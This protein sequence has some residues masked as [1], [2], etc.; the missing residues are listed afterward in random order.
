M[1]ISEEMEEILQLEWYTERNGNSFEEGKAKPDQRVWWRCKEGHSW[2]AKM[3]SRIVRKSKCPYCS[4]VKAIIGENDVA[5]LYPELA[6]EF[7][8]TKNGDV[9]L[10]NYKEN[11]GKKVWWKCKKGHEWLA[12]INTRTKRGCGCP[13][14][15]GQKI[16]TGFNDFATLYPK[17]AKEV[18]PTK[19]TSVKIDSLGGK[20]H[21]KLI[22]ICPEGHEYSTTINKRVCRGDGCP[23]CAGRYPI[24]GVNDLKTLHPEAAKFWDNEINGDMQKYKSH[25][26][27][28]VSWKCSEG[29]KWINSIANQVNY[30]ECPYCD[31]RRLIIGVNDIETRYPAIALEWD[32]EKNG[33]EASKVKA[34]SKVQAYWKCAKGHSWK[35]YLSNRL[36]GKDCPYC[37]GKLPIKGENDLAT[38]YPWLVNEWNNELNRKRPEEYLPKSNRRVWWTCENGHTWKALISERTRGTGCPECRNVSKEKNG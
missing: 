12:A 24:V 31:R 3:A 17:L 30:N 4:G 20:S 23:Y 6:L 5:T 29:H 18:H 34:S 36:N 28:K 8:P 25:S 35:A 32:I 10:E 33:I 13:Y 2:T 19:N 22:W 37:K 9:K 16:L 11:S 21:Q 7:H 38:C 26:S 1:K 15:S 14:C 27:N